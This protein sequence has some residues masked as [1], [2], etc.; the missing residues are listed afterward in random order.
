MKICSHCKIEKPSEDFYVYSRNRDGLHSRCKLCI[1]QLVI[2]WQRNNRDLARA[3]AKR[4]YYRHKDREAVRMKKW[5][6]ENLDKAANYSSNRRAILA[7]VWVEDID[8]NKVW[9]DGNG[10]CGICND[11]AN[12]QDW[13]L[14]HVIPISKHGLHEYANVQISHPVCNMRKGDRINA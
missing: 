2:L 12:A 9:Q 11:S 14:D 4:Y 1:N 10:I 13:H 5:Q 3:K 8:R 7:S 6:V